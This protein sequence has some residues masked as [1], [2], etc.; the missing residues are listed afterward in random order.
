[1][2]G[3]SCRVNQGDLPVTRR[4]FIAPDK[5]TKSPPG[6]SQSVHSSEEAA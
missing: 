1:M 6:R 5:G 2:H 4:E 3:R